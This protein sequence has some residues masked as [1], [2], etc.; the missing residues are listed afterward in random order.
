MRATVWAIKR[1]FRVPSPQMAG[2]PR[3]PLFWSSSGMNQYAMPAPRR[4]LA[5][6]PRPAACGSWGCPNDAFS[7]VAATPGRQGGWGISGRAPD[8]SG[9]LYKYDRTCLILVDCRQ[10]PPRVLETAEELRR[11]GAVPVT[12]DADFDVL[13][14]R[15]FATDLVQAY[16]DRHE[17]GAL[18]ERKSLV[19]L[20][21]PHAIKVADDVVGVTR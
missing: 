1:L 19:D 4:A 5:T 10:N 20:A 7:I 21:H 15:R 14:P 3:K 9:S 11:S 8:P 18:T 17:L 16:I 12:F 2:R 6:A 13:S